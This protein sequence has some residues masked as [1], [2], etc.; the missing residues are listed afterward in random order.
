M[1][2]PT[3]KPTPACPD[4]AHEWEV[5]KVAGVIPVTILGMSKCKKCGAVA[6]EEHFP[7]AY[8]PEETDA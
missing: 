2:D 8:P 7:A 6:R 3:K 5:D 4:D 1:T